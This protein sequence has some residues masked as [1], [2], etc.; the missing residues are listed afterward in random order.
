MRW[1][2]AQHQHRLQLEEEH[3]HLRRALA[4]ENGD[5]HRALRERDAEID[6]LFVGLR[7]VAGVTDGPGVV[8]LLASPEGSRL[9]SMPDDR[10]SRFVDDRR[11]AAVAAL[12]DLA[13]ARDRSLL[14]LAFGYLLGESTVASVIAG[15]TSPDQVRSNVAAAGWAMSAA[16]RPAVATWYSS[17]WKVWKLW[18]ST[19]VTSHSVRRRPRS[20]HNP[21]NPAPMMTTRGRR[22]GGADGDMVRAP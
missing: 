20:V 9:A 3:I 6:R 12:T 10:R 18:R 2:Y 14:E 4:H 11:L 16:F 1:L 13:S 19:R 15:A 8:A 5:L 7:R 17:G 21:A 22:A